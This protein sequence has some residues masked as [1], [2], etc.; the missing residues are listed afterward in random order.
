MKEIR[1]EL[2]KKYAD[3]IAKV[4]AANADESKNWQPDIG[5]SFDMMLHEY[6]AVNGLRGRTHKYEGIP[7]D[8]DWIRFGEEIQPLIEIE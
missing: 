8:F 4:S 6:F 5:V 1:K 3:V 2:E 7:E